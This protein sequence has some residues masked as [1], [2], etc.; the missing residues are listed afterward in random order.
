MQDNDFDFENGHLVVFRSKE[1]K[2]LNF[3]W[4]SEDFDFIKNKIA[5]HNKRQPDKGENGRFAELITDTLVREICAYRERARQ[6]EDILNDAKEV[7]ESIDKA[8]EYLEDALADL[9]RIRGL[10]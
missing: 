5:E 6:F 2:F 3:Y 7:Q 9:N 1:G 4:Y 8:V 10:G